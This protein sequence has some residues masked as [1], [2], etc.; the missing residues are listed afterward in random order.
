MHFPMPLT[1]AARV[2][3]SF[4]GVVQKWGWRSAVIVDIAVPSV[5]RALCWHSSQDV[6]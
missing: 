5:N 2:L 6:L 1:V 4:A 3:L